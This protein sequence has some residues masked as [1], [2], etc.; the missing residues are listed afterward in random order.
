MENGDKKALLLW[1]LASGGG[2]D[3]GVSA[4]VQILDVPLI[5]FMTLVKET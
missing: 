4:W 2:N 3:S 1:C 5:N